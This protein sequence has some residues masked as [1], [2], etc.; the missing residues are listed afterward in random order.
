MVMASQLSFTSAAPHVFSL[1]T[2]RVDQDEVWCLRTGQFIANISGK[3]GKLG[4]G[5]YW[6]YGPCSTRINAARC[7]PP[8]PFC[9]LWS[10]TK[11]WSDELGR[12]QLQ[13]LAILALEPVGMRSPSIFF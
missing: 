2:L 13:A 11:Q 4:T 10:V 1:Q 12:R 9:L 5:G 3:C 8:S 7:P 6:Q